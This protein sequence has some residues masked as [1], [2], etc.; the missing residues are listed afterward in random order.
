MLAYSSLTDRT[1]LY[2]EAL[3]LTIECV[4]WYFDP[5]I[6]ILCPSFCQVMM[7]GGDPVEV[8][9]RVNGEDDPSNVRL[10]TTGTTA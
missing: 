1:F 2:V 3:R 10:V 6:V 9:V 7:V 4:S 8:H 5:S